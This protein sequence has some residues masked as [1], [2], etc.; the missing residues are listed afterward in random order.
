MTMA[1]GSGDA[2][3][4]YCPRYHDNHATSYHNRC[5]CIMY[6]GVRPE[7]QTA[8]LFSLLISL[9]QTTLVLPIIITINLVSAF[10]A[11]CLITSQ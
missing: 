2:I 10:A 1:R 6:N 7:H 4:E 8:E 9:P 11:R 5:D 3:I